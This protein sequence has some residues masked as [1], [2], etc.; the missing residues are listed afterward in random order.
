MLHLSMNKHVINTFFFFVHAVLSPLCHTH[1]CVSSVPCSEQSQ[2]IVHM[3]TRVVMLVSR[4]SLF[5]QFCCCSLQVYWCNWF[6]MQSASPGPVVASWLCFCCSRWQCSTFSFSF[7]STLT[8]CINTH[9]SL[10]YDSKR[11][12]DIHCIIWSILC[13]VWLQ[14]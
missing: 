13:E 8:I 12:Y 4:C 6:E 1:L 3:K 10:G 9:F 2:A 14:I 5:H 7:S 11:G